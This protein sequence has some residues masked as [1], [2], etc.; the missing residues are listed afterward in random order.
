MALSRSSPL[1]TTKAQVVAIAAHPGLASLED[2]G[3]FSVATTLAEAHKWV[4]DAV[5]RRIGIDAC[6]LLTNTEE[7]ERAV[8][9]KFLELVAASGLLGGAG[10]GA[11]AADAGA[12]DYYGRLAS[13]EADAFVPAYPSD[14][15]PR[16]IGEGK[17]YVRNLSS[18]PRFTFPR[19]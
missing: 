1:L 4:Y 15:T 9:F 11:R 3:E 2:S 6:A 7:L 18:L 8:A 5:K 17:P 13:E 16:V 12:R 10:E 14:D 19:G